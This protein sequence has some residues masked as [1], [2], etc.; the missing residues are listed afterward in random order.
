MDP[1]PEDLQ[2]LV[3]PPTSPVAPDR[4]PI[5][6]GKEGR[7]TWISSLETKHWWQATTLAMVFDILY[8]MDKSKTGTTWNAFG[9]IRYSSI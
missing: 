7:K 6:L 1:V 4:V 5:W 8:G 9:Q 2:L 3:N